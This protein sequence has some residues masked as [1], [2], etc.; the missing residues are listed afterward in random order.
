MNEN[1]NYILSEVED[2]VLRDLAYT[3]REER[4]LCALDK[5]GIRSRIELKAARAAIDHAMDKAIYYGLD[6]DYTLRSSLLGRLKALRAADALMGR[7]WEL[8]ELAQQL[9][10]DLHAH[11]QAAVVSRAIRSVSRPK[12]STPALPPQT[13]SAPRAIEGP[14]Q[15]H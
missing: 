10:D 2:G 15:G 11:H 5:K 8:P 7:T 4:I 3:I 14:P 6:T 13:G 9:T 1:G 12:A